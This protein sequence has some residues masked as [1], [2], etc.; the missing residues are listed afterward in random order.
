MERSRLDQTTRDQTELTI[1]KALE[2]AGDNSNYQKKR[3]FLLSLLILP[4]AILTSKV[5]MQSTKMILTFLVASGVGSIICLTYLNILASATGFLAFTV[6]A[7]LFYP[8][9]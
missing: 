9:S 8:F 4:L 3:L 6:G 2:F 5:A 7:F 1:D